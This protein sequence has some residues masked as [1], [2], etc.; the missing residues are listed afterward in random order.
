MEF[1]ISVIIPVYNAEKYLKPCIESLLNQTLNAIEFI[2]VNDGSQD[3]SQTIIE[4]Y[5]KTD[6][7]IS[8]IQQENQGVSAARNNGLSVAK[9]EYVGFVDADDY[10]KIDF[11][12][13][14]YTSA[15]QSTSQIIISNFDSE[16]DGKI[17]NSKPIFET[18]KL[19]SE[20]EIKKKIV[21]FF[22]E[23]DLLNTVWNKLYEA[24]LLKSNKITFPLGISNGEDGLFNI[25]V[26]Y[27]SNSAFFIDYNGYFY[28]D[29]FGSATRD[30][31]KNDYF[32]IALEKF[33]FDYTQFGIDFK[34]QNIEQLKSKRLVNNVA[35][36]IHVYFSSKNN[37]SFKNKIQYVKMMI[38]NETTQ[39]AINNFWSDLIFNNSKYHKLILYCIKYKLITGLLLIVK[40]SDYRNK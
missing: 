7:R 22:V 5:Q 40:Y 20:L 15:I 6:S 26:F 35:S 30:V 38:S 23:Q 10:V 2:F 14:L 8:I 3:T 27:M 17:Y 28:R 25:Q 16:F 37:M 31:K 36:L 34:H 1:K 24:E 12:E 21:P 33:K 13:Q 11:F 18:D 29:V 9:G 19:F 4:S 39:T 32:R